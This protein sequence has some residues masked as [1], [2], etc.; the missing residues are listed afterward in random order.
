MEIYSWKYSEIFKRETKNCHG[1]VKTETLQTLHDPIVVETKIYNYSR[2]CNI[3]SIIE[4][5]IIK[6]KIFICQK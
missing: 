5:G 4:E 1:R 2:H 6:Q 3:L